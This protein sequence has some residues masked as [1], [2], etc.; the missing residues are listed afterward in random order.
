MDDVGKF[1]QKKHAKLEI[2]PKI[3]II[4]CKIRGYFWGPSSE[5]DSIADK[6][7]YF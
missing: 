2:L 4:K 6:F 5:A 3:L 1:P 7:T